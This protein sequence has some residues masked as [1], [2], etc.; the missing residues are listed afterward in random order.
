MGFYEPPLKVDQY[1]FLLTEGARFARHAIL[2]SEP[3]SRLGQIILLRSIARAVWR[4]DMDLGRTLLATHVLARGYVDLESDSRVLR[5][6]D[7]DRF[8]RDLDQI[9]FADLE[10]QKVKIAKSM[11]E[12]TPERARRKR[13]QQIR[14]LQRRAAIWAP[15]DRR[16]Q[17]KGIRLS[18]GTTTEPESMSQAINQYWGD[19]F[20][21]N[22]VQQREGRPT[23]AVS[24]LTWTSPT[25]LPPRCT[26]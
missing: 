1:K 19:V 17:L 14:R 21:P 3:G 8:A 12:N 13:R 25:S 9:Q 10:A 26:A 16:L 5:L 20:G 6:K 15:F 18:T 4:Q 22:T 2:L 7:P 23:W 24:G 11:D